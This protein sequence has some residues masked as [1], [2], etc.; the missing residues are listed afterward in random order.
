ML[1]TT[2]PDASLLSASIL[3]GTCVGKKTRNVQEKTL[4][5]SAVAEFVRMGK[6]AD[7]INNIMGEARTK[8]VRVS[9]SSMLTG[10]FWTRTGCFIKEIRI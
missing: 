9:C 7:N 1:V 2:G 8:I 4:K 5:Q 3:A 10:L 6:G